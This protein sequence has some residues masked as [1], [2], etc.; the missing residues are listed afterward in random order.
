MTRKIEAVFEDNVLKPLSPLEG[1]QEHEKVTVILCPRA[2]KRGLRRLVGTLS[3]EEAQALQKIIDD[4]FE[5]I[6]GKW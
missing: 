4:E 3:H 5:R 1:L 6:E 2:E